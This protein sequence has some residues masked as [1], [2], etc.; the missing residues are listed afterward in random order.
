MATIFQ[1]GGV[2]VAKVKVW[3]AAVGAFRWVMRSTHLGDR[4]AAEL[5]AATLERGSAACAAGVM[6]REKALE[7]VN[8]ILRFAGL[9]E[10]SPVPMTFAFAEGMAGAGKLA[11]KTSQKYAGALK[12][13]KLWAG[14]KDRAL[15]AWTTG[16]MQAYY[17]SML[18][19]LSATSAGHHLTFWRGVF[20]RGVKLGHLSMNPA[21][22]VVTVR[23]V[24]TPKVAIS[25]GECAAVLRVMR[26]AGQ[27]RWVGLTLLGWHTGHRIGDLLGVRPS[28]LVDVEGVKA[29]L[30]RP[31]KG[32]RV[33][34]ARV[35]CLPLPGYLW[36]R[37]VR[38]LGGQEKGDVLGRSGNANGR[39][40][41]EFVEWL[42]KAGIDPMPVQMTARMVHLK[43]F[44]S[45]R[46]SMSSRL[47]AA[48]VDPETA[49]LVTAHKSPQVHRGYVQAEVAALAAALK[50]VR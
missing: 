18:L 23:R 48:G 6:S 16:E 32:S 37:L 41:N 50:K 30:L 42:V 35:V 9:A 7:M 46:H 36:K 29:V 45:F 4:K 10:L 21:A 2:W 22:G 5:A 47:A 15:N 38:V 3:D 27:G 40:S 49:R 17:D 25:R 14:G 34:G 33:E 44:H 12:R 1:R 8:D 26:R 28:D 13:F 39:V 43:S 31:A 24:V 11:F 19:D 20:G